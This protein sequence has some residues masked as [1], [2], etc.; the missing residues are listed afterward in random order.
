M[1][2][3]IWFWTGLDLFLTG[4]RTV[5]FVNKLV[6]VYSREVTTEPSSCRNVARPENHGKWDLSQHDTVQN[7]HGSLL[8]SDKGW[9][10]GSVGERCAMHKPMSQ[11]QP[12]NPH[13]CLTLH[14][15]CGTPS[16]PASNIYT[17]HRFLKKQ[18][19]R[20][21]AHKN[22]YIQFDYLWNSSLRFSRNTKLKHNCLHPPQNRIK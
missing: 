20:R 13:S 8:T 14:A 3:W 17:Q 22:L 2:A 18:T 1:A 21:K 7:G 16:H 6:K 19:G 10:E 12:Q 9:R 15:Y 11:V 5:V 4:L